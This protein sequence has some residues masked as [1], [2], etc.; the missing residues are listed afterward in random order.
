MTRSGQPSLCVFAERNM[1]KQ[2]F[3]LSWICLTS[4]CIPNRLHCFVAT[5]LALVRHISSILMKLLCIT[6]A[7]F[8]R[9][10]LCGK[11]ANPPS[12]SAER[13]QSRL[14]H[15]KSDTVFNSTVR[16]DRT[17]RSR[18]STPWEIQPFLSSSGESLATC[19]TIANS[20][21]AFFL[22]STAHFVRAGGCEE[23]PPEY[24]WHLQGEQGC[25]GS[26]FSWRAEA[27]EADTRTCKYIKQMTENWCN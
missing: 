22:G 21:G 25:R 9:N 27:L 14:F 26:P 6:S 4:D 17:E 24:P 15:K 18:M 1:S 13:T 3:L 7:A 12:L 10:T 5:N 19:L 8:F 2:G 11:M 20:S 16:L 23:C